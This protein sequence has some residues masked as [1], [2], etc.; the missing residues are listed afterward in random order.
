MF[1]PQALCPAGLPESQSVY[2]PSLHERSQMGFLIPLKPPSS[3]FPLS[4]LFW[5][6]RV[7]DA[8]LEGR[9]PSTPASSPLFPG[10]MR[11]RWA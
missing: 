4:Y 8:A 2:V 3:S 5:F 11:L 6:L 1:S 7:A 9:V 10:I